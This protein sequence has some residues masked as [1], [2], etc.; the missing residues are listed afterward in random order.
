MTS[1]ETR[2]LRDQLLTCLRDSFPNALATYEVAESI[3]EQL[4]AST[5]RVLRVLERSGEVVRC[6]VPGYREAFWSY[7]PKADL[8]AKIAELEKLL[9]S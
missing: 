7:I 4:Y 9:V 3:P 8:K 6:K 2:F 5:Y 1:G